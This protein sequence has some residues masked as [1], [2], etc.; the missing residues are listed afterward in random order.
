MCVGL[1]IK[2]RLVGPKGPPF[3]SSPQGATVSLSETVE[4][5][6]EYQRQCQRFLTEA[7]P[8]ATGECTQAAL[9]GAGRPHAWLGIICLSRTPHLPYAWGCGL[10]AA[11]L[12]LAPDWGPSGADTSPFYSASSSALPSLCQGRRPNPRTYGNKRLGGVTDRW[13]GG[14]GEREG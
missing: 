10:A 12:P 9:H 3:R 13:T 14:H 1:G 6:R 4:K 5:W 7:P 11:V 2:E 8:P